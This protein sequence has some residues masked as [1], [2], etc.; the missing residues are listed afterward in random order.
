MLEIYNTLTKQKE[1]FIPRQ[2]GKIGLY[3]CGMTVY[4]YCHI[5]HARIMVCFDV[6]TRY[7]R[8]R[9]FDV[10]YV[11]NITDIDDKIIKRAQEN[12]EDYSVLTERFIQAMHEDQAALGVLPP[13]EEPRATSYIVA[14]QALIQRLLDKAYAYVAD[15]GDVYYDVSQFTSYGCL[16]HQD[17]D[18]LRAG[19]RVAVV[20]VKQD[21]LDFVLWK[22]AKPGEPSWESPWGAGRPGWHIECS[23]M[24]MQCLGDE[25]DLHGGG[26]DLVFPHHENEIAQAVAATDKSFA[27]AWLHVGFVQIDKEKMSKSLGNFFTI[28]EVLAQCSG[29]ALRYFLMASHYR[30][31][32]NYSTD[33]LAGAHAALE[34]FYLT[35]RDVDLTAKPLEGSE[36]ERQFCAAMDDDFN[37]PVALAVLFDLA[38]EVNRV[39]GDDPALANSLGAL[40]RRLANEGLGLLNQ[41]PDLFLQ[42]TSED[43]A[44]IEALI[45]ARQAAREQKNWSEADRLRDEL[46][47]KGVVLEDAATGTTWRQQTRSQA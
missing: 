14:M 5:G 12:G 37:T 3:V 35:L 1:P 25:F 16:A 2:P 42:A 33:A 27:H 26:G 31:P 34:R 20:D 9:G 10:T 28:R 23:A 19:A 30:S 22:L 47:A 45:A 17:L 7:L 36:F 11:R 6:M 21:P 41:D 43:A 13:T 4:D 18:K 15:N 29:E 32:L 24:S 38:R 8:L 40:L 39:R 46:L 44:E